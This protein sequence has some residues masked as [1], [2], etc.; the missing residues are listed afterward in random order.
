MGLGMS[1]II[2]SIVGVLWA[3]LNWVLIL[4]QNHILAKFS[5]SII[6]PGEDGLPKL[7]REL[8]TQDKTQLDN[9]PLTPAHE[10]IPFDD[11][12]FIAGLSIYIVPNLYLVIQSGCYVG[13][14]IVANT[15]HSGQIGGLDWLAIIVALLGIGAI[16]ASWHLLFGIVKIKTYMG[17]MPDPTSRATTKIV[18]DAPPKSMIWTRHLRPV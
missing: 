12:T 18:I 6:P 7:R 5:P 16:V 8:P 1:L 14:L 17:I 10:E 3:L 13:L 9:T 2:L 11:E 15:I 4:W